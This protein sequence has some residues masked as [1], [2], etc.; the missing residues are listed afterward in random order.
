MR[1]ALLFIL[2]LILMPVCVAIQDLLPEIPPD[3]ER[4]L[5]LP[6]LFCFGALALPLIPALFFALIT[7]L[8]Q[9]LLLVK[10]S[11]GQTEFGL[12]MP[13]VF[14]LSWAL[15]LQMASEATHGMRWEVHAL[16]SALVTFSWLGGEFLMICFKRGGFPID[17]TVLLRMAVP[18]G[19]ALLIAPL[20]YLLLGS[21]VPYAPEVVLASLRK[22]GLDS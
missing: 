10:I 13:V 11:S 16:G 1:T 5:L 15:L 18:A 21:L 8:V 3:K 6:V 14:F 9:G 2:L 19:L 20:V 17:T 12:V 7:A 22:K 4:I